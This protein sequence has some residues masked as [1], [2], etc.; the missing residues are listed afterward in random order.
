MPQFT[1]VLP[2]SQ[3]EILLSILFVL[4]RFRYLN[5]TVQVG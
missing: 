3:P 4:D 2:K 1:S 5:H